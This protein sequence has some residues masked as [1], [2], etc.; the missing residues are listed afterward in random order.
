MFQY[1]SAVNV[2]ATGNRNKCEETSINLLAK[3]NRN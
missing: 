2:Y 1:K 3:M